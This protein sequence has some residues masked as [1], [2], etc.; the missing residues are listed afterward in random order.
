M[1]HRRTEHVVSVDQDDVISIFGGFQAGHLDT[2]EEYDEGSE[3]TYLSQYLQEPKS[4]LAVVTLPAGIILEKFLKK[5]KV[6]TFSISIVPTDE[7]KDR[8]RR[9]QTTND[10]LGIWVTFYKWITAS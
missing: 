2:I 5:V 8:I 6:S 10:S 3:W 9:G 7:A 1:R 4:Q